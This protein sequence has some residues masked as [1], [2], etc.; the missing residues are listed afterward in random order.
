MFTPVRARTPVKAKVAARRATTAAKERIPAKERAAA[1][2]TAAS[3]LRARH[4]SYRGCHA[5]LCATT[6]IA[7]ESEF[8][9]PTLQ[10]EGFLRCL[11]IG[12]TISPNTA[13]A[14][15]CACRTTDTSW[16]KGRWLI[17]LKLSPKI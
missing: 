1:R 14:S 6:H 8:Q 9:P 15:A 3:R 7:G 16:R 11:Q 2:R 17:G 10:A 12:L 13:L 4:S 5:R